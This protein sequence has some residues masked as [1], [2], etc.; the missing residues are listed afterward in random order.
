MRGLSALTAALCALLIL[1]DAAVAAP[2]DSPWNAKY[3]T[4]LPLVTQDGK[5]VHLYDDLIKDKIV[6]V[7]FVFTRC[8]DICPLMTAR[9]AE[10]VARLGGRVGKDIFVYSISLDPEHDTPESM[11]AMATAFD[12]GPGWLFLTG[13]PEDV[14]TIRYKLGERS[15][16]L[17]E[18]RTDM[19]VGNDATGEWGRAS[20]FDDY[21]RTVDAILTMDPVWREQHRDTV[22]RYETIDELPVGGE[23]GEAL[24]I[25][26]CSSCH[27]IGK[28][29]RI[30]PDLKGVT[31]RR[32]HDWLVKFLKSPSQMIKDKDPTALELAAEYKG[33]RMPNLNLN[34]D[35]IGDVLTYIEAK[36]KQVEGDAGVAPSSGAAPAEAAAN[37]ATVVQ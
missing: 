13:K 20:A 18:H 15:E 7:N 32:D 36:E 37:G 4:N 25:K 29:R 24:F 17:S 35:D 21:E 11:K 14:A 6:V 26:G 28:G 5:T 10:I 33:A 30:G 23:T 1:C 16:N 31:A 8:A 27:S 12:A 9:I 2:K 3:F 19:M 34:E 22:S